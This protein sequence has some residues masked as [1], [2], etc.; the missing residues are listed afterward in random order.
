MIDFYL[1]DYF[2]TAQVQETSCT[3]TEFDIDTFQYDFTLTLGDFNP[4]AE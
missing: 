4:G 2:E 3:K 1:D